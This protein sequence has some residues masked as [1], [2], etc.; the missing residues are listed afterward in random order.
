MSKINR[1]LSIFCTKISSR[2]AAGNETDKVPSVR[3]LKTTVS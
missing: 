1:D 2:D 3:Q